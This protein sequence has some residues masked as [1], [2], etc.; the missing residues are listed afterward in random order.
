MRASIHEA[1]CFRVPP[2][3][4]LPMIEAPSKYK[5]PT[6]GRVLGSFS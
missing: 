6:G 3:A 4:A 1:V 5:H 2:R